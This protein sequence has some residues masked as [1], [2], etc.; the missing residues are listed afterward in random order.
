[1]DDF[2]RQKIR[3]WITVNYDQDGRIYTIEKLIKFEIHEI[4]FDLLGIKKLIF[5][6]RNRNTCNEIIFQLHIY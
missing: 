4:I 1:M 5:S 2:D 6:F 3:T